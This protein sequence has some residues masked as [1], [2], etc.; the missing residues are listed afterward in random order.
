MTMRYQTFKSSQKIALLILAVLFFGSDRLLAQQQINLTASPASLTLPDG[1]TV[2]MWGYSC[3]AA[4]TGSTATCASLNPNAGA[5]WSPVVITV[6]AGQGLTINL[7][8][9]LSFQPPTPTGGTAPA[10][11][12]IPTSLVI[13]GQVGGGLGTKGSGC[14]GGATCTAS[15]AHVSQPVTWSTTN[16]GPMFNPPPQGPRVQSFGTEVPAGSTTPLTWNFLRPGTYLLQSGTHPSMQVPMGLYG[17]VVVTSAPAGTTAG[18]AYP[19]MG[20]SSA[21]TYN[22]ELPLEFSEIDPGLNN[23]VSTAVNTAGFSATAVRDPSLAAGPI[24]STFVT[25]GGSG[26]V[27]APGVSFS[28]GGCSTEP[29]AT[30][31]LT[32][33]SVTSLNVSNF[34]TGCTSDPAISVGASPAG[35]AN[36]ASAQASLALAA[37]S[38]FNCS[39]GANACYPP[40]VNYTPLYY[41]INGVAFNKTNASGSLFNASPVTGV[42]TGATGTVLV[43][44]VNAGLR[45]HLPSIVGSQTAGLNGAGSQVVASGFSLIAEDGNVQPGVPKVQSDVFM[46]AGKTYD[47]MVNVPAA[48]VPVPPATACTNNAL[49]IFDRELSLSGNAIN[50][51]SG[52]LAYIGINGAALPST[53]VFTAGLPG[54]VVARPDTYNNLVAGQTFTISDPS[55]GVIANDTNVF[56][57]KVSTPPVNGIVNLSAKGTFTYVPSANGISLTLMTGGSG[58]TAPAVVN[59]SAPPSGGTQA[60]ATATVGSSG[61]TAIAVTSNG[62]GYTAPTVAIG[63]PPAGGTPATATAT[64]ASQVAVNVT[65]GGT[66]YS[67]TPTVTIDQ[68]TTGSATATATVSGGVV[69]AITVAITGPGYTT[70]PNITITDTTGT[71]ATATAAFVAGTGVITAVNVTGQGAGYMVPPAVTI[72]DSTGSSGSGAAATASLSTTAGTIT[73]VNVTYIGSGYTTPPTVTIT[74]GSGSNATVTLG[75]VGNLTSDSFVYEANGNPA[76]NAT[77]TLGASSLAGSDSITCIP[78]TFSSTIAT[79]LATKTPGVL[80]SCTDAKKLPLTVVP[81][82]VVITAGATGLQVLADS[83][84][85]FTAS[86][87]SA[88]TYMFTFVAQNTVGT[89]SSPTTV[90][91]NFPTGSGLTVTVKDPYNGTTITD[92]RWIIEEDRTFY[93]NPNCTTN[94]PP[95]GCPTSASGIVPTLGTNFHTSYMPYVAQGCTGTQSCEQGQ[96]VVNPATGQHIAA[97]C[98]IGNGVCR[99]DTTGT[100]KTAVLP[101][102]VSLDPTKRYYLSVLPGDAAN[103]FYNASPVGHGMGGAPI[104]AGQTTVTVLTQPS[105]Y[106]PGRLSVFVFEDDFPLNGEQDSGGGIDVLSTHEPGLGGFQIH[107]W[108]AMGGNGD[109]TG[110]MT[111]DMFNQPLSNSL[112][113]T[114]DPAT[115]LD[116]CPIA[117]TPRSPTDP[118]STGITGM[119]VTCPKY[120]SDMQTMSPLA[121]Q[122]VIANLMPGRWGT[123]ATPGADR[124]ARGEEWL[125]TNTLDGQKAHDVFT[126][127]G[128]PNYFQEFGPASYHVTI[129]FANPA[130]INAR[131]QYVCNGTDPNIAGINCNNTLIGKVTGEHIS[132]APDERLYST[133]SHDTYY[134]S[135]CFISFG[136]PDGEDFAFTK[137]D[138]DGN[139]KLTGLPDGDWRVT[140]FDQWNDI[141]VDGLSTPVRLGGGA[142]GATTNMGDIASTQ[143]QANLYTRTFIDDNKDGVSQSNENGIPFANVAVRLR[144]GSLE[145]LLV[146]D[147]TGTANFN[148]TFPLFSWYTVETDTTRYKNTGT[149]VVYDV[150]GPPDGTLSTCGGPLSG[151]GFPPCGNS[152]IGKY[153]ANTA[154]VVSVPANLRVPGAV[155]CKDADCTGKSI[156]NG[157]GS[158]D[159]PSVCTTST[160]GV[161]TC[162][163]QLSSGRIDP[164]TFGVEGWQGFSGQNNF[165]EFGKEPY[166]PGENGGI[167]GHVIYASTRPFDDPQMLVQTQWEPLVP[168]VT[169]NLYQEGFASDGVT[170]TLTLVDTTQTSS[171]D[172]WAQGFRSDGIPNMNCPGQGA[173]SG[174]IPDLFFFSLYNQPNY[175]DYY[176]NVAH[177]KAAAPTALPNNSQF[178]CYDGM[179]S[180]NQ[181]QPA[182]YDGMYK[183]PSIT[184]IDPVSGKPTGTNCTICTPNHTV[185][186]TDLYF[187]F[188]ML[189]TGKYVV[190][191]VLPPGFEL[192]KEED[193]NILIG[194]NFIAPVTQ[195]FGG[196]SAIF[197]IPDQASVAAQGYAGP[198]YNPFSAQNSTQ[199]FG[200]SPE[201]GIVPGFVPEPIW[202]CVG[203]ARVVPDYI[204]LYP[205]SKQ[206]APFAG[207]T[208]NLCDRKEVTLS[209]QAGAIA[210]FFIYTSTHIASK[211]TG[212]VTDDFTSEFDPFSPQYGEKFSPPDLPVSVKDWT[213]T[214][215]SRVYT[216]HW[217]TYNGMTYSTWEVNPPNPTGYS[218]TMMVF[219]LN[220]MGSGATPDPLYNPAYSQFCYELPYMPGTT[221]YLDTPVI[222]TS[223]F[224]G[225]GYNNPDCNYPDG[226]PAIKEVDG[227]GLG[228]WVSA[229]GHTITI[230][231]LGLQT[232]ANHGYS[233]PSA[234][235]APFNQ[236]T[237]T[238][239][240]GFGPAPSTCLS[241]GACP[242]V[243]IGGQALTN[244]SWSDGSITGTVPSTVPACRQQQAQYSGVSTQCGQLLVTAANGKQS[245]DTVTVTIEN[246]PPTH[247]TGGATIQSVI[248]AAAPGD[249]IIV[250]PGIYQEIVIMWKPV[251]LQGVGAASSI[252]NA[253]AHPA[254]KLDPW[255]AR[256]NCLFGLALNGQPYSTAGNLV[257]RPGFNFPSDPN[258]GK[259]APLN[260]YDPTGNLSCPGNGW[261][262]FG[263]GPNN[264]QVDRIPLEGIVGWDTTVNGNLAQLLQEPSLMGAYE[265][266]GITVVAKG[267]RYPA[268]VD[269]FGTGLDTAAGSFIAHEGQFPESATQGTNILTNRDADCLTTATGTTGYSSN[270]LCN[271]SRIDGLTV[272]NSSQ[273]GGGIFVHGWAHDLEISN[274]RVVNNTGTM[275]G[276]ITVGQGE[277]PDAL[278]VG[279][280]GDP[281]AGN[282]AQPY[283]GFD[284]QPWTCVPGAVAWDNNGTATTGTQIVN[285]PGYPTGMQLPYCYNVGVNVHNNDI[286]QNSSIGDELFSA[287]PAGA[288]GATFCTGSDYYKFNYNWVCGNLGTGDGGGLAHI[289][290][291]YKGDIE[292]NSILFNQST[293]PTIPANGGGIVAMGAAPDGS[294]VSQP[295]CGSVTD[296]DCAPGLSDG[297][298]PGLVINA[299]LIMGNAAESGSGGGI[300]FQDLDGTEVSTF[301]NGSLP[302]V[303]PD[304]PPMYGGPGGSTSY[305]TPWNVVVATNNIIANNVAGWDGGG[306]SF[307]DALAV[308]FI[309]NTVVSNDST[310]SAGILFNTLGA[311]LASAPG[312]TCT[313]NCGTTSPPQVAGVVSMAHTS[314]LAAAMHRPNVTITCAPGNGTSGNCSKFS[315]PLLAND[316]IWQNRS[317]Y[318]GVGPLGAGNLNQQ[319][320]VSLYN[321][322]TT[323]QA[324]T[325]PTSDATTSSGTGQ[326]ITG[327]TGA[328][329]TPVTYWEIGVRGDTG[330]SNHGSGLTLTPTNSALTDVADYAGGHNTGSNPN[331]LSQYC[332]GSRTPPEFKSLG[333]QVPPGISD[334]TVPNPIFNLTPTATVDEGNNWVNMSWGP[335]SLVNPVTNTVLGNYGLAS[336]SPA[337]D[338]VPLNSN[339]LPVGLMPTLAMDFYGQPRPDPSNPNAFDVGAT[340]FQGL[341]PAA[342]LAGISPSSGQPGT[343]MNVTLTG[344]NLADATSVNASLQPNITVTNFSAVN[345]TTVTATLNLACATLQGPHVI[346]VS[347]PI[348]SPFVVFNVAAPAPTLSAASTS[349]GVQGTVVPVTLTGTGLTCASSVS[350][351]G[352]L[353]TVG[354]L[355][356]APGGGSISTTFT[357]A[358]NA[359]AGPRSI[360]V[361]TPGGQTSTV[362]FN[363][364]GPTFT[365]STGSLSFGNQPDRTASQSRPVILS[366]PGPLPVAIT[367]I[368]FGGPNPLVFTQTNNCPASPTKLAVGAS[369]TINVSFAPGL[370]GSSTAAGSKTANLVVNVSGAVAQTVA[371][372]GTTTVA[373]VSLSA[374]A[375]LPGLLTGA[376][377]SHSA[378]V[379]LTN[380]ATASGPL[381]LTAT[382]TV[383]VM[384]PGPTGSGFTVTGGTCVSGSTVLPGGTCTIIVTYNPNGSAATSATAQLTINATGTTTASQNGPSFSAN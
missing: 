19:A 243:T 225:A 138:A 13:V 178:K 379:T 210:K 343:S 231:S 358:A 310:A 18:T 216:D 41:L 257:P 350:G 255:R 298:G 217:G 32:N 258:Y 34:G 120:E 357:I 266:A 104:S 320:V 1:T 171:W 137:C 105:P 142:T 356:V 84:G 4:V 260:V 172:D 264:P 186:S 250:D 111:Y 158:S 76:L 25:N 332:N 7:T 220:D 233:G 213:G 218:P 317:F 202:P 83:N 251:R 62:S 128:E 63:A 98:D 198:G 351:F 282:P 79:Y 174:V 78:S 181:I 291:T 28:G 285:P 15:P 309:N 161:T 86:G 365:L 163:T 228:P 9:S 23:A 61:V 259:Y 110:Q 287:T 12:N 130:I 262:Y 344:M 240:Y 347:T 296:I 108:D 305:R 256:V 232:V 211:F 362:V 5:T 49:P 238:R 31:N 102:Q 204:S 35:A 304:V 159:P 319:N 127:I 168:H 284:Q 141:L 115:G 123:I 124:I 367:G 82:S 170:P 121:G 90:T 371:V 322:F 359:P 167:K 361:I 239:N 246:K 341:R 67:A 314:L 270:F 43:R 363:V 205:Q 190:E 234:T 214:E 376:T 288:G 355:T 73:A 330:P 293:N 368:S 156:Q 75:S 169:I 95:A 335:L 176:N 300:R 370:N 148:E 289:G 160:T 378:T 129:G 118:T 157:P 14:T 101:S 125:Q 224:A 212:V 271:P 107:L 235:T 99:P 154:E 307:Q 162:S 17:M 340:E 196:L 146:T 93:I 89:K 342:S 273:G 60:T 352:P 336:S 253:N 94:P 325:Q 46:A 132:R 223:A 97:T 275:T 45:M 3:G 333:Y 59:I 324:T 328:C 20:S 226:T 299:N 297:T 303:R 177:G 152:A 155:Y 229:A 222:P 272:T 227:D 69:T 281:L 274:N 92:Y 301:P 36:S 47:V 56:G 353:I 149:H 117:N 150:G 252:I 384:T 372:S 80:A 346:T 133:T 323:T 242:N 241:T 375:P 29:V 175:L 134:W 313:S 261:N 87:A 208:R 54:A 135:Q 345:N 53:G 151:T 21:V 377:T 192:V 50:R 197:I 236:K 381:T 199:S 269:V 81:G 209:D 244:V 237:I 51:D 113:G 165:I 337:I 40:A 44:L 70:V 369:C 184:S 364:V 276:G 55:K 77:V 316:L 126:R 26:Y 263:G 188:P 139:F 173:S 221:S 338:Y 114:I 194:D 116:A 37:N 245:I 179:H 153:L 380:S 200:A 96:T 71:S 278:I 58:Y 131:R 354:P 103:P 302:V 312:P 166:A 334:A 112:A 22:S 267:V 383:R 249:L 66:G 183:F 42:A 24:V 219:C 373:T 65:N 68:P 106:P 140:V 119:I 203:E 277:S 11:N 16:T 326:I 136:D 88:G 195:E 327:G 315:V 329:V 164:P 143:W 74:G 30:A 339:T 48:C 193:K 382:P 286:K 64:V 366:N 187:G 145:N 185:P 201:N 189:P 279:N 72:T 57:V 39:G 100:G 292:H 2:P 280:G 349:S 109:F 85:G 254:G 38:L 6:P 265:G 283:G 308:N 248:D 91:L 331:L 206:V 321:S 8:N 122:A 306:V 318:I 147:F 374:P 144:D 311:P 33:G 294:T 10:P 290:F 268:G 247:V 27:T 182:P 230:T 52:M 348:G 360:S 180:W 295:E 191:V 207:A 215:I